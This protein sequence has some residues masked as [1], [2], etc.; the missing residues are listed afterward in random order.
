MRLNRRARRGAVAAALVITGA[1]WSGCTGTKVTEF[2]AGI[3]SQVQVPRDLLSVVITV[4]VGGNQTFSQSY[5]VYDSQ[6]RLPRTLGVVKGGTPPGTPVVIT[7]AGLTAA[8]ND[9]SFS[10]ISNGDPPKVGGD[11][12][13]GGGARILRRSRQPYAEERIVFIPM[14]LHYS[15]YDVDCS[16]SANTGCNDGSCTCKGAICTIPDI[17]TAT[18]PDYNDS[19][20]Y[21]STNTCFRPFTSTDPAGSKLPGCMDFGLPPQ[22][23]DATNCI[24][25]LPNTAS[26]PPD[27]G[28]YNPLVPPAFIQAADSGGGL[29]VRAVFDNY[30]S[31][32]L[33]YEGLCPPA[34]GAVAPVEGYCTFEGAPQRF[35]LAPGLCSS[36]FH[37]I[38]LLEASAACPS[39]TQ[40]QPICDDAEGPPFQP[41]LIDGGQSTDGGC[42]VAKPLTPAPSALY[43]LWDKSS[44]MSEFFGQKA[45]Q[46]VLSVSLGDP[47]FNQTQ[48]AFS[49]TPGPQT[50]CSAA[51]GS[52]S[53]E[54]PLIPFEPSTQGQ[55]DIGNNL[56]G[57]GDGGT[58]A[59][60]EPTP[61]Y[62][63]AALDGTYQ[64]LVA[65]RSKAKEAYN[66]T[67]V[68]LFFDRDIQSGLNPDCGAAHKSAIQ[69]AQAALSAGIETYVVYLKNAD[70]DSG[71]DTDPNAEPNAAAL[72]MGFNTGAKYFFNAS[73]GDKNTLAQTQASALASVVADLGSC[74][75]EVPQG[76]GPEAVLQFPDTV[77]RSLLAVKNAASCANDD[78]ATTPLWVFDNQHIRVCQNT[79]QRLI[80][81]VEADQA[82][83]AQNNILTGGNAGAAGITVYATEACGAPSAGPIVESGT[84]PNNFD[85]NVGTTD[86]AGGSGDDAGDDSGGSQDAGS[87]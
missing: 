66:R 41:T 53:F 25:A 43:I 65:Q 8:Y 70:F 71:A 22:V 84:V 81:A 13:Q 35:Q 16:A 30:V 17:D 77:S 1:V 55:L 57:Q 33:D 86:D 6:V 50:D 36:P 11:K 39:K 44:G 78:P 19:L 67:A 56:F 60:G 26:V 52:N 4:D 79:C 62:L 69:E 14:P 21:G 23:L 7:V 58:F 61:W 83:T 51:P 34:K 63:E 73:T 48:I 20:I 28:V 72:A 27:S 9:D 59:P 85:A 29:N 64:A 24:Y 47:V 38:T 49:Y 80:T 87:D 42:N 68:M 15:C 46:Q 54:T 10:S 31:E 18:L 12:T 82:A 74:V 5:P 2:V 3:S 76:I 37:K 32:V 45:L 75:Y 40:F